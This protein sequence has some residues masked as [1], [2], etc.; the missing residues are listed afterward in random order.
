MLDKIVYFCKKVKMK[1]LSRYEKLSL[2][3]KASFNFTHI[4][5]SKNTSPLIIAW[6]LTKRC[7]LKCKHCSS[8]LNKDKID[9]AFLM[10]IAKKLASSDAMI[11]IISGGEPLLVPNI[12]EIISLL[13]SAGKKI[14]LNTNALVLSDKLDFVLKSGIDN[15]AISFDS[16]IAEEHDLIRGKNGSFQKALN[17]LQSIKLRRENNTPYITVRFVV[18]KNNYQKMKEYIDFFSDKVDEIKFQ[19]VHNSEGFDEVVD[20]NVLFNNENE[21][22]KN[23]FEEI[24]DSIYE[25]YP[26]FD[27]DYIRNIPKFLLNPESLEEKAIKHCLPVW[28]NFM[29]IDEVGDSKVCA[30]TMGNVLENDIT[31]IWNNGKRLEYLI[32]LAKYGKCKIPCWLNCTTIA[33]KWQGNIIQTVLNKKKISEK[34]WEEFKST[35]NYSGVG[36]V[37]N[38]DF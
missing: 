33:P 32:G 24:L 37:E 20:K 38:I 34:G 29:Y 16:H 10:D 36:E 28:F 27:N 35:P 11:I 13:K 2:Y 23:E 18:M 30:K 19:P 22:V 1:F 17:A 6:V 15:I 8:Y 26:D 3:S 25:Q 31:E 12:E 4:I 7:N 14:V 9:P 21:T 5:G